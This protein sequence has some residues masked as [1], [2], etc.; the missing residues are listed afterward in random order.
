MCS[1][2]IY[3]LYATYIYTDTTCRRGNCTW[4][5]WNRCYTFFWQNIWYPIVLFAIHMMDIYSLV[6]AS[7]GFHW[8]LAHSDKLL[9]SRVLVSANPHEYSTYW[10]RRSLVSVVPSGALQTLVY[11][12]IH[13][14]KMSHEY[15]FDFGVWGICILGFN[16][17]CVPSLV[18]SLI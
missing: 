4:T 12:C 10:T 16:K 6:R 8:N 9:M 18:S 13:S 11:R 2:Y 15:I 1:P 17:M 3:S 7:C 14:L 5:L